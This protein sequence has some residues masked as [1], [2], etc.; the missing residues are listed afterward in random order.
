MA[1][2]KISTGVRWDPEGEAMT[3][4]QENLSGEAVS[5]A[6]CASQPA[7]YA[8]QTRARHEKRIGNELQDRGIHAFVPT[9][10]QSHRWSDRTKVVDVPLFSCYVFVNLVASSEQR[11]DVLKTAGVLSFVRVSGAPA[12]IPDSQIESI[13]TVLANKLP[14]STCGFIQIG[15][16]V[17]IRGGSL[18]GV[19]GIL[20][21]SKGGQKL[22]ISLELL[23]QSVE[24]SVEG[25]AIE[26]V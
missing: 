8:I 2:C 9:L 13:Q 5:P 17:R 19:E 14:I 15:Q 25:Y 26:V 16:R 24:I 20:T 10:R 11:L 18:E 7:W 4:L 21:A 23:Q 12:P 1:E 6:I 22:V 3:S